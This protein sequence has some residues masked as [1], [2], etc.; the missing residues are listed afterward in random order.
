[1]DNILKLFAHSI[2]QQQMQRLL[3]RQLRKKQML[4]AA[5]S[6]GFLQL[7]KSLKLKNVWV[8]IQFREAERS[9]MDLN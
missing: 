3:G 4:A 9:L 6:L 7:K 1:M 5:G 2:I 8:E